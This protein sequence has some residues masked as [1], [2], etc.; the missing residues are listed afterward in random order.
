MTKILTQRDLGREECADPN[1][2][3]DHATIFLGQNCHAGACLAVGY[4]KQTGVLMVSC[5]V[6]D[7]E[8][9]GVEVAQGPLLQ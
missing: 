9:L 1:C 4:N 5:L 7:N 3:G 8:I 2:T 6:C